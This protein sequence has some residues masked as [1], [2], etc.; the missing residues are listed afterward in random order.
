[1]ELIETLERLGPF[2]SGN[3]E[4]R[5]AI[6]NARVAYAA[7]VG[8]DHVRCTLEGTEGGRL[9]AICF[10]ATDR[11]LGQVLL[12]SAGRAVHVAGRLRANHWQ[13]RSTAQMMIDDAVALW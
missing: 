2:G 8:E 1:M 7:V 5:F 9:Q 12:T 4:P 11:P 10:R 6:K 3:A 13:G